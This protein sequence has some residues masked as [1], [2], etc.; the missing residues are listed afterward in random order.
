MSASRQ[1]FRFAPLKPGTN[2]KNTVDTVSVSMKTGT[3]LHLI[4]PGHT[5]RAT[6]LFVRRA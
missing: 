3:Q 2:Q 4:V 5:T 1:G 6:C